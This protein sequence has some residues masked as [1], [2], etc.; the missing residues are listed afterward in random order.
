MVPV[1]RAKVVQ[2]QDSFNATRR[3]NEQVCVVKIKILQL[4]KVQQE[5][6]CQR[7]DKQELELL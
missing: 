1:Q 3:V 4:L 6:E 7:T 5:T 2:Y